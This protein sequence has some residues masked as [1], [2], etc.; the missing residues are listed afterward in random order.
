VKGPF[1]LILLGALVTSGCL[2]EELNLSGK[3]CA[4]SSDCENL[5][6]T[7]EDGNGICAPA[8]IEDGFDHADKQW[9]NGEPVGPWTAV[10]PNP[11][12][13][14]VIGIGNVSTPENPFLSLQTTADATD[15]EA[16]AL[17]TEVFGGNLDLKV[18]MVTM[19]P[20]HTNAG[21]KNAAWIIWNYTGPNTEHYY[22]TI[23]S[24]APNG[25][26]VGRRTGVAVSGTLVP[27]TSG[28]CSTGALTTNTPY[29][30]RIVQSGRKISVVINNTTAFS[31]DD[32]A[33]PLT[34]GRVGL[35]A[36][37]A[38]ARFDNVQLLQLP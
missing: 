6:C 3:S 31:G 12:N 1:K 14:A 11:D 8:L 9:A 26:E 38:A 15:A 2:V 5:R 10:F 16:M 36:R 21:G 4:D 27:G 34:Q 33:T 35:V 32:P 17:S 18:Q 20:L 29:S 22:F 30:I 7:S 37:N 23:R 25:C 28:T 24:A 13:G 19:A